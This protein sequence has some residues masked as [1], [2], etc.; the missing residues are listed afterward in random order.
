MVVFRNR[1]YQLLVQ[2][3]DPSLTSVCFAAAAFPIVRV[4]TDV[5]ITDVVITDVVI[6]DVVITDVV[7]TDVV[8]TDVVITDV[9]ITGVVITD[10]VLIKTITVKYRVLVACSL[11]S[12]KVEVSSHRTYEINVSACECEVVMVFII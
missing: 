10:V 3:L 7:I 1:A 4:I 12:N 5:V 6:T 2:C 11:G 8:I 9:V